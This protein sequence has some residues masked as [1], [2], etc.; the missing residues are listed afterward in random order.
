MEYMTQ[1]EF[2]ELAGYEVS[3]DAYHNVI[4]PMFIAVRD[5]VTKQEFVKML[6]GKAFAITNR[7]GIDEFTK[8]RHKAWGWEVIYEYD[9]C[10][11]DW[12]LWNGRSLM[13]LDN[14]RLED[15]EI[16]E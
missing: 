9:K 7:W 2:E 6:D 10:Y 12:F 8:L 5:N 3:F 11:K 16:V 13:S 14:Y 4:E 15:F 1:F